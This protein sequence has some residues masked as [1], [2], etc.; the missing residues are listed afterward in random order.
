MAQLVKNLP[1]MRETWVRSLGWE[2]PLEK[3]MAICS[4]TIAWKIPWT[5]EPGRLQSMGSQ[6]VRSNLATEHAR[7]RARA[8]THTHTHTH[9]YTHTHIHTPERK[10]ERKFEIKSGLNSLRYHLLNY[11]LR[12]V[13]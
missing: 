8:H 9:P 12:Q 5:E 3:E 11:D 1:A 7:V 2:D 6:G 4:S 10:K 13:T